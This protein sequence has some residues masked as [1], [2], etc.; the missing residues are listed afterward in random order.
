METATLSSKHQILIPKA[1]REALNLKAGQKLTF[2]LK[3]NLVQLV[4]EK[5]I[6]DMCGFMK[7]ANTENTRDRRDR[8]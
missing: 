8:L 4:P 2:V 1:I 7:G 3:G 5:D 6:A